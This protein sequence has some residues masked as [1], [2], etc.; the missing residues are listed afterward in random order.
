MI[1]NLSIVMGD[2]VWVKY[3]WELFDYVVDARSSSLGNAGTA[4]NL[5]SIQS[6]IANPS[7]ISYTG[8]NI[9][10]T[11][12]SR[13]AGMVN[14]DLFGIQLK[15]KSRTINLNILYQGISNIPDTR[16]MLLDWGQDGQFGTNDIGEGNGIVDE[17][18]RLDKQKLRYFNQHQFGMHGAFIT[19]IMGA[20]LGIGF[21]MLSYSLSDHYALGV[22]I[23]IGYNT[24]IKRSS[25]GIVI[26]NFPASG[27]I[28]DS[29]TVEGTRPSLSIGLH[30]PIDNFERSSVLINTIIKLET[31]L[32]NVNV[33]SQIRYGSLSIDPA[34]GIEIIYK[35][36]TMIRI[37][38]NSVN[39]NTGGVGL[40]WEN[41]GVDYAFINSINSGAIGNHHLI[42]LNLS[43]DWIIS[44]LSI[45]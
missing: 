11:H 38:K 13:F 3:G 18:E 19:K 15:S 16:A 40:R 4:Y 2:G 45:K 6:S 42:S 30:H 5:G 25:L 26:R 21:K 17:G 44:K 23:D 33:D 35:Q 1:I 29:G 24:M 12:Q 39:D 43:S 14:S 36:N 22:G 20:P 8:N 10:M 28:W 31:S 9:S 37:G 27:L 34:Y 41:I 32:S 7:F